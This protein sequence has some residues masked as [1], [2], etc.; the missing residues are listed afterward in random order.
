[1]IDSESTAL[2]IA[3]NVSKHYK[4][5]LAS[6]T[7]STITRAVDDVSL[8]VHPG[9][10]VAVVGE[11]GSGKTTLTR[12]L[13]AIEPMTA[14]T[15]TVA[16]EPLVGRR[17]AA[18]RAARR[19]MQPVFQDPFSSLDPR[20]TARRTIRES[21]DCLQLGPKDERNAVVNDL[22][23][24]VGLSPDVANRMPGA[25]SGG[26]RQRVAI[27][28]ALACR[29]R[30]LVADEP[31]T[32]LDVS[33]QAQILNLLADLRSSLGLAILLVSHDLS[34]V[35]H[36]SDR[37]LVMYQGRVVESGNTAQVL[38]RPTHTYTQSLIAAIPRI[39]EREPTNKN[40]SH[41]RD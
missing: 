8:T 13:L 19:T 28:A 18:T 4:S 2:L 14:G 31:V 41:E 11:S 37:V 20:W 21:L 35:E 38:G 36:I 22:L 27:A 26:Q 29:P 33:V 6:G 34:V 5:R 17:R 1:M 10:I 32:A 3:E 9:E 7:R 15:V 24:R 12:C 30:L 39:Q 25:L 16:G 40:R 23:K